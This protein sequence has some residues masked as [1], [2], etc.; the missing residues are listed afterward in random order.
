M[1]LWLIL[2]VIAQF[3]NAGIVLVDKYLVSSKEIAKPAVYAFYVSILSGFVLF[4]LPFG[5][6]SIPSSIIVNLS[7]ATALA[8]ILSIVLLYS[9]LRV[10]N[11]SDVVPVTGAVSAIFSFIFAWGLLGSPLPQSFMLGFILLIMGSLLISHFRFDVK[12]FLFAIGSG[13]L[14]GL[15][16]VLIKMIFLHTSFA[17]GFFWS[18]MANVIG[19]VI[20]LFWPSTFQAVKASF[21]KSS[22][23]TKSLLLGNKALAGFSFV[24]VLFA[25][26]LGNVAVINALSALQFVFL[27]SFAFICSDRFPSVFH[28]EIH[29]HRFPHK[30]IGVILIVGGFFALF[31]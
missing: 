10:T 24:L 3:L 9:A 8:Y 12:S 25:I 14:F 28:G 19:G 21:K 22:T 27:L 15:S 29:P 16:S 1:A 30:L 23:G 31:L 26:K 2:V 7:L 13:I 17:D 5:L 20:L 6:I 4:L 11:A 18:R